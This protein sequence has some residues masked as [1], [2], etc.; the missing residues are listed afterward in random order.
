MEGD[1][2]CKETY[3]MLDEL[4]KV[5]RSYDQF[6][7]QETSPSLNVHILKGTATLMI[8]MFYQKELYEPS[9]IKI[10]QLLNF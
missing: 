7:S 8:S 4:T 3:R 6:A 10:D 9:I 1:L 2:H 5:W